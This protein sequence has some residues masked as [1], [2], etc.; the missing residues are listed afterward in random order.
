MDFY[1]HLVFNYLVRKSGSDCR[2]K[3]NTIKISRRKLI[4]WKSFH[5]FACFQKINKLRKAQ[6]LFYFTSEKLFREIWFDDLQHGLC[7]FLVLRL[8]SI[9]KSTILNLRNHYLKD[10]HK[11]QSHHWMAQFFIKSEDTSKTEGIL[12]PSFKKIFY[13]GVI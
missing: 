13:C 3:T 2:E 12:A 6:S 4:F 11:K 10:Y 9:K 8:K 1:F 7:M 5:F